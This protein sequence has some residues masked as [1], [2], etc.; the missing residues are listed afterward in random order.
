M[1]VPGSLGADLMS[2]RAAS[3]AVSAA[4]PCASLTCING[5]RWSLVRES[6]GCAS[7]TAPETAFIVWGNPHPARSPR[8]FPPL[9]YH[10]VDGVHRWS[11]CSL[12]RAP[13]AELLPQ[14]G[15]A[16]VRTC[17]WSGSGRS[18][19][20]LN[21][22]PFSPPLRSGRHPCGDLPPLTPLSIPP[23]CLM[24]FGIYKARGERKGGRDSV[25]SLP[26]P[27]RPS[28]RPEPD[29]ADALRALFFLALRAG[30]SSRRGPLHAPSSPFRGG[31]HFRRHSV[32]CRW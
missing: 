7:K 5:R 28:L 24:Y 1:S 27:S 4:L 30:S 16:A 15:L 13:A 11:W 17:V 2:G 10:G 12:G 20:R 19:G 31:V 9:S 3:S 32:R 23:P 22:F 6:S 21:P 29:L 8:P 14:F 25:G 26:G 18:E